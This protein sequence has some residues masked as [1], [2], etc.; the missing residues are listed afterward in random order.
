MSPISPRGDDTCVE[1]GIHPRPGFENCVCISLS[2]LETVFRCVANCLRDVARAK[3]KRER[4][5]LAK[6]R[7]AARRR[8]IAKKR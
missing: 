1:V 8:A 7:A 2:D 5:A 6:A 3:A 4:I